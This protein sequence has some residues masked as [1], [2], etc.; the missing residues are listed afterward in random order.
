MTTTTTTLTRR[1]R[2]I[3]IHV[4]RGAHEEKI[5]VWSVRWRGLSARELAHL[6]D[7]D[8]DLKACR[9]LSGWRAIVTVGGVYVA[10]VRK[11][12]ADMNAIAEIREL[13][14]GHL[15]RITFEAPVLA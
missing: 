11:N 5:G 6:I 14:C 7:T 12:C 3:A 4:Y 15:D 13:V 10:T 9:E 8:V 1:H 2:N